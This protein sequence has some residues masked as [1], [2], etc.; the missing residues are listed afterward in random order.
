VAASSSP[1]GLGQRTSSCRAVG[2]DVAADA[3]WGVA[4]SVTAGPPVVLEACVLDPRDSDGIAAFCSRAASVAIDAPGGLS[5]GAHVDDH[6]LAPKFRGGRCSEV[7]LRRLCQISVPWVTPGSDMALAPWMRAGFGLWSVLRQRGH[8]PIETYPHA[9]FWRLAGRQLT[10]KQRRVGQAARLSALGGHLELPAG[11]AMWSHDGIDALAAAFVA[12][13]QARGSA[14]RIDCA[15][16][17]AWPIHD[18]SSMW[19]PP[20]GTSPLG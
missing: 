19:L 18:G 15:E 17:R 2:F 9:V 14:V 13:H 12:W 10:G 11:A 16:D 6:R 1:A 8:E 3:L 4:L 5:S 7:A 20:G